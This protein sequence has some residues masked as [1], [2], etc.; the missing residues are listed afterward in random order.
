M[1]EL[2]AKNYKIVMKETEENSNRK[3]FHVHGWKLIVK[4][5]YYPKQSIDSMKSPSKFQRHFSQ[6]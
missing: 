2:C 5:P 6:K 3:I 4:Q 1:K